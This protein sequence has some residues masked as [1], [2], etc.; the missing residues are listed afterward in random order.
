M[1][2]HLFN[3]LRAFAASLCSC[4]LGVLFLALTLSLYDELR[5]VSIPFERA[6]LMLVLLALIDE[7]LVSRG[8]PALLYGFVNLLAG[9]AGVFAV[10]RGTVFTP[11]S[12]GYAVFLGALLLLSVVHCAAGA[13]KAPDSNQFIWLADMLIVGLL[14][15][16]SCVHLLERA[17]DGGAAGFAL[18]ALAAA[19]ISASNLR[20]GGESDRVVRGS[21]M[22]GYLVLAAMLAICL[23]LTAAL[24]FLG[25]GQVDSIVSF[26]SRLWKLLGALIER[27]ILLFSA[28]LSLNFGKYNPL[29]REAGHFTTTV[30][31]LDDPQAAGTAPAWIVYA[32][33]ALLGAALVAVLL[34][35]LLDYRGLRV[36][37]TGTKKRRRVLTRKSH[38]LS[39]LRSVLRALRGRISFEL[40]LRRSRHTP[41]AVYVL[42][43]RTCRAKTLK[44]RPAESP[45]AYL[46]R[47]HV[48]LLAMQAPSTLD[49]L[50]AQLNAAL[51]GGE[52]V[53]LS[54]QEYVQYASQLR[55]LARGKRDA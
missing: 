15:L 34:G 27:V 5:T 41:Q 40:M 23:A 2:Q 4:A 43:L 33:L 37:R 11:A 48:Q 31:P 12:G 51:Y 44:K 42:A 53:R 8:V 47:L 38:L 28:L 13:M 45:G 20:C 54:A 22:G 19:Y 32:F 14:L 55:T 24:I 50:A 30:V 1:K 39:A 52:S 46:Y 25:R 9:G 49:R 10:L 18:L 16:F 7:A 6:V 26:V 29:K 17:L 36:G 3:A 21:G 35:F